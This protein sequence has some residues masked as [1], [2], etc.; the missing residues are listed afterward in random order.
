MYLQ[1][2]E[3]SNF[4]GIRHLKVDFEKDNTILIG[5]NAWGKSSLLSALWMILGQEENKL[6]KFVADDLYVPIKI[7]DPIPTIN[8]S[9]NPFTKLDCN[10]LSDFNKSKLQD[11]YDFYLQD[12]FKEVSERIQI[13]L[14]FSQS[15][16]SSV[17]NQSPFQ[18]LLKVAYKDTDKLYKIHY[19]ILGFQ[20]KNQ[21]VT[22]N[23][24]LDHN[25][26]VIANST[27]YIHDLIKLNPLLRLRDRRMIKPTDLKTEQSLKDSELKELNRSIRKFFNNIGNE[28]D[29]YSA[30]INS[31][32]AALNIIATKYLVNY[33]SNINTSYDQQE[34]HTRT[35]RDIITK[36]V[37]VA[38]LNSLTNT[39]KDKKFSKDKFLL[40]MLAGALLMAK[41]SRTINKLAK[42]ILVLEDIEGRFHP[43]LLLS[44][45]A[46][47]QIIP[48]QKIVTTNS[49]ELISSISL[50]CLRRLCRQYYD[51]RCFKIGEK[52]FNAEDARK[53]AFHIRRN[54]PNV[55]FAR[56]WILVEG[57][58]EFW[59]LTEIAAILG[60]NLASEG[61]KII[62]YA[63][64]GLSPLLKLAR[65]LGIS[66]FV[67][68]DGD[69]AGKRYADTVHSYVNND[70]LDKHLCVLP[71]LD[72]EHFLYN[73]EYASI[74][75]KAAG[76]ISE[77][78][79]KVIKRKHSFS[80]N[81]EEMK[82]H[83]DVDCSKDAPLTR[84]DVLSY[85]NQIF[86]IIYSNKR[87]EDLTEEE[88]R[89]LDQY[90][91]ERQQVLN[92]LNLGI[93]KN[94]KKKHNK[95]LNQKFNVP[96]L[97]YIWKHLKEVKRKNPALLNILTQ[98]L[99]T[100]YEGYLNERKNFVFK[101]ENHELYVLQKSRFIA[102]SNRV[103]NLKEPLGPLPLDPENMAGNNITPNTNADNQEIK[104]IS[105]SKSDLSKRGLSPTKVIN[106][107]I[108]KKTKPGLAIMVVEEMQSRGE[109]GVPKLFKK[110]F[111]NIQTMAQGNA[112]IFL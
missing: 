49:P 73:S 92:K 60:L 56:T 108:H 101:T 68:T 104:D 47:L 82:D 21:F 3:I 17:L 1:F 42:P 107:A 70:L 63:Q 43:T 57:E 81:F 35:A 103:L 45:W 50:H 90:K 100:L 14:I 24:L 9:K 20:E 87:N 72:I 6:C 79:I 69:D 102:D 33:K 112:E 2:I 89:L 32:I 52:T 15:D 16:N 40:S 55:L 59:M 64:C 110:M 12:I 31:G 65:T 10:A 95:K 85:Y 80:V 67:L 54:R 111:K 13:D 99:Y 39:L 19:Q 61:I 62:E 44:L 37:S 22:I 28:E 86:S 4:R 25:D 18:N 94:T 23:Q 76:V 74:Y 83:E 91:T 29:L 58:T 97:L 7:E 98:R 77:Q 51:V 71:D 106:T 11:D 27:S 109:A 30:K 48:I 53:I 96:N 75:Q 46:I 41:G 36:P 8:Q 26:Q 105:L 78:D 93:I 38:T 5:E 66:F 88:K 34:N 84:Q